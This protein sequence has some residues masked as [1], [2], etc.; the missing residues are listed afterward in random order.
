MFDILREVMP[1][2]SYC[3]EN[4]LVGR[5]YE[6][7]VKFFEEKY[8][9]EIDT[10]TFWRKRMND[11]ELEEYKKQLKEELEERLGKLKKYCDSKYDVVYLTINQ[12]AENVRK[13]IDEHCVVLER[14]EN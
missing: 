5:D 7:V 3:S 2:Y 8:N 9:D 11:K 10:K 13:F 14:Y 1:S 4:S 6:E 12:R